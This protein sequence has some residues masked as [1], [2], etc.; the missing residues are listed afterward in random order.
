MDYGRQ[1][2]T[3]QIHSATNLEMMNHRA[4]TVPEGPECPCTFEIPLNSHYLAD[5]HGNMRGMGK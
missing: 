2:E 3:V 1:I 4:D 5:C